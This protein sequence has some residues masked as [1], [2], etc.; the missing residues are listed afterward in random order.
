MLAPVLNRLA[1]GATE[2]IRADHT[3]VLG[4]F[5][6][7]DIDASPAAKQALVE[8]VCL[9][10]EVHAE[11]EEE[12]F[13]PAVRATGSTLVDKSLPEHE[14]MRRLI[15]TLRETDPAIPEYDATF[16][17]LMRE[18]IHHV[19]D[20]ETAMLPHAE[21]LLRGSL[22]RLGA[23]MAARRVQL[24]ALRTPQLARAGAKAA[25]AAPGRMLLLAG[26]AL[27]AGMLLFRRRRPH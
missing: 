20:E 5:H 13:Y 6:R 10:L 7:Y 9:A 8:S 18:V 21:A 11:L 19:A 1:P 2:M 26:G 12:I 24:K 17:D 15:A 14:E 4:A 23:R 16:M 27:L 22:G 3:R 25:A